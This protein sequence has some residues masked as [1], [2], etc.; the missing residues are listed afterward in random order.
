MKQQTKENKLCLSCRRK[1]K[2]PA[3]AVIASCPRYY[4]GPRI[5]R[6][7]WKQLELSL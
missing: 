5:K 1:C 3:A 7:T 4:A 2:Q 6:S